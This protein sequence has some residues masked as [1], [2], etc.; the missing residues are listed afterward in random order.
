MQDVYLDSMDLG[1]LF[2]L[3][4]QIG[5]DR[6]KLCC[7]KPVTKSVFEVTHLDSRFD[8]YESMESALAAF[9]DI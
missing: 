2:W 8:I 6:I 3:V 4:K 7:L 1:D 9:G 5:R